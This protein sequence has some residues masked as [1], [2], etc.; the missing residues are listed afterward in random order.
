ME[1]HFVWWGG[2]RGGG[3]ILSLSSGDDGRIPSAK[4][5][6]AFFLNIFAHVAEEYK[7]SVFVISPIT[8]PHSC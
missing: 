1:Q 5:I 4:R 7:T 3:R 6:K 2:G 8:Q